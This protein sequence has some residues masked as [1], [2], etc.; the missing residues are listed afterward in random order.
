M[1]SVF[2]LPRWGLERFSNRSQVTAAGQ[3]WSRAGN[4]ALWLESC[5]GHAPEAPGAR[6][7]WPVCL[8]PQHLETAWH[9]WSRCQ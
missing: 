9:G 7:P 1:F 2:F 4:L 3:G 5:P 8:L 6:P